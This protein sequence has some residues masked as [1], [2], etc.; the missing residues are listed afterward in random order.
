M[1]KETA[2][3]EDGPLDKLTFDFVSVNE[4]NVWN[5]LTNTASIRVSGTYYMNIKMATC[6]KMGAKLDAKIN[7][8]I[9]FNVEYL[10]FNGKCSMSRSRP[11]IR[12]LTT[13]DTIKISMTATNTCLWHKIHSTTFYGFYLGL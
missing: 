2:S 11:V 8:K 1:S 6:F 4:G 13:G 10:M 7:D 3:E 9:D 5:R 12:K